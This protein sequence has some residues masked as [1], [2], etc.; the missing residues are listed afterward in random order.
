MGSMNTPFPTHRKQTINGKSFLFLSSLFL[1][2][3]LTTTCQALFENDLDRAKDFMK[4]DMYPQAI[5]LLNKRINE[6]PTDSEAHYQL[7]VCYLK[8]DDLFSADE[9]FASA[10]K[11][12]A[13]TKGKIG[14]EY[15]QAGIGALS[16][17]KNKKAQMRFRRAAEHNPALKKGIAQKCFSAAKSLF[18]K[19][20]V[21]PLR[22]FWKWFLEEP[23]SLFSMA[24]EYDSSLKAQADEIRHGYAKRLLDIAKEQPKNKRKPYIKQAKK[25]LSQEEIDKVF[26]PPEPAY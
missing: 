1:V 6:K 3:V 25:Y 15:K 9:R 21:D 4:A 12:N 10:V 11:L 23:D 24:I 8:I 14:M 7:G 17:G 2:V 22:E 26:P 20:E 18:D 5:E 16:D 13:D 19:E